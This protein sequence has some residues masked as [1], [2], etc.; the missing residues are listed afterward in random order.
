MKSK[1]LHGLIS[2]FHR[3]I[4]SSQLTLYKSMQNYHETEQNTYVKA[5]TMM[6]FNFAT[7]I[8]EI[9]ILLEIANGIHCFIALCITIFSLKR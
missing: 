3:F 8:T 1:M 9:T 6:F 5:K 2:P 7:E 4:A